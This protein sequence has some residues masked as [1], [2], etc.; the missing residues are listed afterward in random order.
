M[1]DTLASR[2]VE[3]LTPVV[4]GAGLLLETV[5][6][7]RAGRRST[8]RVVVDLPDGQGDVGVDDIAGATRAISEALDRAD[9]NYQIGRA[10]CRERV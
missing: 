5:E 3:L 6:V 1:T 2:L 9:P 4:A 7:A 10:S 8:V